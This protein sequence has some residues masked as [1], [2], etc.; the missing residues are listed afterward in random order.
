VIRY[1]VLAL[2]FVGGLAVLGVGALTVFACGFMDDS[3]YV[4]GLPPQAWIPISLL[5]GGVM[6]GYAVWE[7]RQ[8]R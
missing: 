5:F 8:A 7:S 2:W 3:C 1:A 4:L 6:V